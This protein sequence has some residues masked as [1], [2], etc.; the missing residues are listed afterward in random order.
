MLLVGKTILVRIR[1]A[2]YLYESTP[3][4]RAKQDEEKRGKVWF[5]NNCASRSDVYF[6]LSHIF[7]PLRAKKCRFLQRV[8]GLL[9]IMY[10]RPISAL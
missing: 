7:F 2:R 8:N 3:F 9:E 6:P 5:M 1:S 4:L 10:L